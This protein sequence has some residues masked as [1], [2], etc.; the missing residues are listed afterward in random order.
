MSAINMSQWVQESNKPAVIAHGEID[1]DIAKARL[2]W[3]NPFVHQT[4]GE[5]S[6]EEA[7]QS[8]CNYCIA[9]NSP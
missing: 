1:G 8:V 4:T 3:I 7:L 6:M 9:Y 2:L 5:E